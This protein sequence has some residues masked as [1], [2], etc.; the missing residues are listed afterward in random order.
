MAGKARRRKTARQDEA[1][2]K[3]NYALELAVQAGLVLTLALS[4]LA[5]VGMAAG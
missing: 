5:A 2:A 1:D 3:H 4:L